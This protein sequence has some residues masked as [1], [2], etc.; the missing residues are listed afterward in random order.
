MYVGRSEIFDDLADVWE[1]VQQGAS[2]IVWLDGEPGMGRTATVHRF[3]SIIG[4][5]N[6]RRVTADEEE[7]GRSFGVFDR[8][9]HRLIRAADDTESTDHTASTD[10]G[11]ALLDA[12]TASSDPLAM[13]IEDLQ[14]VDPPTLGA[15]RF[16]LRRLE[17]DGVLMILTSTPRPWLEIGDPWRR[18]L[19]DPESVLHHHLDG[20]GPVELVELT[21][22]MGYGG[23]DPT[24]AQRL[25][26]HTNGHPQYAL[27]LLDEVGVHGLATV[28][29]VMP[30][31]RSV[32]DLTLVRLERLD[33]AAREFVEA[34][35]VHSMSFTPADI[36]RIIDAEKPIDACTQVLDS[37]LVRQVAAGTVT[38]AHPLVRGAIYN[39]LSLDR[40]R[41]LHLASAAVTEG[42]A[43]LLHRVAAIETF[44]DDLATQLDEAAAS[45]IGDVVQAADLLLAA[46]R[47]GSERSAS[48]RRL[49]GA[50]ELLIS[51]SY[52]A[53]AATLREQIE[54]GR[55]TSWR[56]LVL[57]QLDVFTGAFGAAGA[58]FERALDLP[59]SD[60]NGE[61]DHHTDRRTIT[62]PGDV[63]ARALVGVAAVRWFAGRPDEALRYLD[64]ALEGDVDWGA[65]LAS[66]LRAM[67]MLHA[68]RDDELLSDPMPVPTDPADRMAITGAV[69]FYRDDLS[70]AAA[71]LSAS[72][73]SRGGDRTGQL[74]PM[75]MALLAEA[76]LGLGR[77]DAAAV[78]AELAVSFASD[79]GSLH[80][81][82]EALT[83]QVELV[84]GRGD[85]DEARTLLSQVDTL[86]DMTPAWSGRSRVE[87]ARA[88]LAT[89]TD[90]V[91]TLELAADRLSGERLRSAL[92]GFG[93]WR[94]MVSIAE[95]HLAAQRIGDARE[96]V[97]DL[98]RQFAEN[99][100]HCAWID[101]ARLRARIAE[102]DGQL[103][104]AEEIYEGVSTK[105][106]AQRPVS[107]A[108]LHISHATLLIRRR[109][110]DAATRILD[111]V[112]AVA[113]PIGAI[114]LVERCRVLR[115]GFEDAA[116]SGTRGSPEH[117]DLTPRQRSVVALVAEGLTNKEIAAE[118]FVSAKT[119][120]Y[121]LGQVYMRHDLHSRRELIRLLR[122][123]SR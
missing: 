61:P 60:R 85:F 110:F 92:S 26:D 57:G 45:M 91:A 79:T 24:T 33:P 75:A 65:S 46:A 55:M 54:S 19:E 120:E 38:F 52:V 53:R 101:I 59:S 119:V 98:A 116:T 67:T 20:L 56:E 6:T 73:G 78:H 103:D 64:Q 2:R 37:G 104:A 84:A 99:V 5:S 112:E 17:H 81:L 102:T 76:E 30:S 71:D 114:P 34:A 36:G 72:V 27:A 88:T 10:H 68:G 51:G 18:L 22:L 43:S 3:A 122:A 74:F 13:V 9:M 93:T 25:H 14:W 77:W 70:A 87:V 40:R 80:A 108:L 115:S 69:R 42:T 23:L 1:Q 12:L 35:A 117:L 83:V 66:Y 11:G 32:R 100:D 97:D 41:D 47:V 123:G 31:P 113:A 49:L 4:V 62:E 39:D 29:E 44:D 16:A 48:Q 58:H 111:E 82:I 7:V 118:L 50:A 121:H 107:S 106:F 109:R 28:T 15:L 94:W 95:A 86:V 89:W 105:S 21:G 96:L 8:I 90:D 63:H